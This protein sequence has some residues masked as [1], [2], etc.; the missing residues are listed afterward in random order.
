MTVV[1]EAFD[2]TAEAWPR[3]DR[4]ALRDVADRLLLTPADLQRYPRFFRR[5]SLQLAVDLAAEELVED[6]VEWL[7]RL[8]L[9]QLNF[10]SFAD[11]RPFTQA[12]LLRER[13]GFEGDIRACGDVQRDQLAFMRRCG[14]NQFDLADGEDSAQIKSVFDEI[15][16]SYQPIEF[17]QK[18]L[19]QDSA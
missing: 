1:I 13:F 5:S 6:I 2:N 16:H 19:C 17:D 18:V 7:P 12:R 9:V 15:S 14:I 10:E 3:F 8:S 4:R 11:G